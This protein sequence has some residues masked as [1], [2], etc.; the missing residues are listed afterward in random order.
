MITENTEEDEEMAWAMP[1]L[2]KVLDMYIS[3]FGSDHPKVGVEKIP[4]TSIDLH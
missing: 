2:E 3:L 4:L 1:L